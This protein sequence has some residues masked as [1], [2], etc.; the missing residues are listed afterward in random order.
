MAHTHN[1][2]QDGEHDESHE[3]EGSAT[4]TVDNEE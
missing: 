4:P 3:L 2:K 1:E